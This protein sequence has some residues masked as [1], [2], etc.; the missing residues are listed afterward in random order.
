MRISDCSSDV[1]S[2]DLRVDA[3]IAPA[4]SMAGRARNQRQAAH[5][6]AA[7]PQNVYVDWCPPN[8]IVWPNIGWPHAMMDQV[9]LI[10][11]MEG[12][13]MNRRDILVCPVGAGQGCEGTVGRDGKRG[14][15]KV[16]A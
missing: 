13:A 2:S 1:C 12:C 10:Y 6:C 14:E 3:R 9:T 5:E 11:C 4:H 8:C 16:Y 15:G 7:D